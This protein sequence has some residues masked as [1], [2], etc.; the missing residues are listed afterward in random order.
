MLYYLQ[1]TA[2]KT[3]AHFSTNVAQREGNAVAAQPPHK[4]VRSGAAGLRN[5]HSL[6]VRFQVFSVDCYGTLRHTAAQEAVL[7]VLDATVLVL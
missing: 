1:F 3:A 2:K 7:C 4:G 5:E 6:P